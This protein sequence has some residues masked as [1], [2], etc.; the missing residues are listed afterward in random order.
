MYMISAIMYHKLR[1]IY[2][3]DFR[4][5]FCI[6]LVHFREQKNIVCLVNLQALWEIRFTCK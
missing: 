5:K 2:T 6:K 3:S 4:A 1:L